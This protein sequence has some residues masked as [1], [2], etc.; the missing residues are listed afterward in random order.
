MKEEIEQKGII[1]LKRLAWI[2]FACVVVMTITKVCDKPSKHVESLKSQNF[3]FEGD[4][5]KTSVNGVVE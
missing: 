1:A 4:T 2:I 3:I 5:I